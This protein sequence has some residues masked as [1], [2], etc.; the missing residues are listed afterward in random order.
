MMILISGQPGNGKTLRAMALMEAEYLRNKAANE[1]PETDPKHQE[2][3]RFFTNI[4]GATCDENPKAFPWVEKLEPSA[5]WT[6]LPEGSFIMY[7][8]A[9]SDGVTPGLERYGKLFPGTGKPG[10][11]DDPRIRAMSTHRHRGVDLVFI[12]QWPSK[13]HHN[14]R[15]LC[16]THI[17]MNR[18]MGLERAGVLTWSRV[19][20]DPYD[21]Q[22]RKKA[23]EEIWPFP[24]QLYGRFTSATLH[25][26]AHKFRIPKKVWGALA[27]LVAMLLVAW[28]LWVFVFRPDPVEASEAGDKPR[29]AA[30]ALAPSGAGV[31][32][33]A[34]RV[35]YADAEAYAAQFRPLIPEAP[36]T[37]PAFAGRP[38][39]SEPH[40]YCIARGQD[41]RDGCSC[42]TEQATRYPMDLD[43]CMVVAR[44]GEAYNPHLA[45]PGRES[46]TRG[47]GPGGVGGVPP[48]VEEAAPASAVVPAA[49]RQVE[50]VAR[51]GGFRGG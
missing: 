15:Q 27:Q 20:P 29:E 32:P 34:S 1:L 7:D 49:S 47:P 24:T 44:E 31:P 4:Q 33:A 41:G 19:Q 26:S 6:Q 5:D 45:P 8:E 22:Q 30:L 13:L 28:G 38:V 37:A 23:E 42:Y 36:W 46:R 21:E 51:Y 11:S 2:L 10:E 3:R 25:T 18:A 14:V 40:V 9:H 35:G 48:T 39:L 12:T 17:H 43:R 50:Q 16:G